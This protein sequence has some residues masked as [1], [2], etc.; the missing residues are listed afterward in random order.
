MVWGIKNKI[1]RRIIENF[2]FRV[3]KNVKNLKEWTRAQ[4][5][6]AL[7]FALATCCELMI[8]SAPIEGFD[9]KY[10]EE[11]LNLEVGIE[12]VVLLALGYRADK[13]TNKNKTR[14]AQKELFENVKSFE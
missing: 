2:V 1:R 12:P 11:T 13:K 3:K 14:F 8:D 9:K 6:I 4:T 5:Y 10:I 7:G